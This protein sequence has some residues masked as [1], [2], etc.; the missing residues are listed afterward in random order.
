[1]RGG[2][3]G[4]IL[5]G[6][7]TQPDAAPRLS[8]AQVSFGL[9]EHAIPGARPSADNRMVY[10]YRQGPLRTYRWLVDNAGG[11]HDCATFRRPIA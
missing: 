6:M 10:M 9:R 2:T 8:P 3:G 7:S 1:M 11:V 5:T 4:L